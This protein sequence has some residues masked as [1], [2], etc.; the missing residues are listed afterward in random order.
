MAAFFLRKLQCSPNPFIC[1][2]ALDLNKKAV[3]AETV[4]N[5]TALDLGQVDFRSRKYRQKF[6]E[7]TRFVTADC[8]EKHL[9]A[10][11]GKLSLPHEAE[12]TG[13]IAFFV[14]NILFAQFDSFRLH[15][16]SDNS[17]RVKIQLCKTFHRGS[18][19]DQRCVRKAFS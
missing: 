1:A 7:H 5:G 19:G 14:R 9:S 11:R 15:V 18:G 3:F 4:R 2:I 17:G 12:K 13:K 6:A 16:R 8:T 10:P